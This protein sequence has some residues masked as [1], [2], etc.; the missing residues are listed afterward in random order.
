MNEIGLKCKY[1]FVWRK[2]RKKECVFWCGWARLN[3]YPMG[4]IEKWI[5]MKKVTDEV[6][7]CSVG[8][9]RGFVC[10]SSTN[11]RFRISNDLLRLT[12][13]YI[14]RRKTIELM[15]NGLAGQQ[16]KTIDLLLI[17]SAANERTE[18][19]E[20]KSKLNFH[21]YEALSNAVSNCKVSIRIEKW[22]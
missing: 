7:M 2:E 16:F 21:N 6:A 9:L 12:V 5:V 22:S 20:Q 17:E 10:G 19:K 15:K 13:S 18:V 14:F 1:Q 8:L 11:D 4:N 3:V